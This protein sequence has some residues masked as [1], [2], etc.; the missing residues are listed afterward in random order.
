MTNLIDNE[1]NK[2]RP[3][4]RGLV[5]DPDTDF[6]KLSAVFPNIWSAQSLYESEIVLDAYEYDEFSTVYM[7]GIQPAVTEDYTVI[8]KPIDYFINKIKYLIDFNV[9]EEKKKELIQKKMDELSKYLASASLED[10]ENFNPVTKEEIVN[11]NE[12]ITNSTETE[13]F[14]KKKFSK[15]K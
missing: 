9:Q 11:S 15:N 5:Y 14:S 2:I 7:L 10:L 6:L 13:P 8:D 1:I 12:N 3:Y 4:F